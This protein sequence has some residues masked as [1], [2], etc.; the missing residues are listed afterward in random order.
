MMDNRDLPDTGPQPDNAHMNR[1]W[2]DG[3]SRRHV[4][5]GMAS[6]IG[7]SAF[8]GAPRDERA[9]TTAQ[10]HQYADIDVR[11]RGG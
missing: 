8:G 2:K 11:E 4:L 7:T 6:A 10:R 1:C 5:A 9:A 3:V